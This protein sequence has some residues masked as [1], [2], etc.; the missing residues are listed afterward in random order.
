MTVL[1]K[2]LERTED[3]VDLVWG[4]CEG[5]KFPKE[6]ANKI[7]RQVEGVQSLLGDSLRGKYQDCAKQNSLISPART[8]TWPIVRGRPVSSERPGRAVT[9]WMSIR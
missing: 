9:F 4:W 2:L 3:A 8:S 7:K 1:A 5:R 6:A